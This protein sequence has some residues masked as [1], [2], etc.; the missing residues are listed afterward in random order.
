M[1]CLM[2]ELKKESFPWNPIEWTFSL[3]FLGQI[4]LVSIAYTAIQFYYVFNP[5]SPSIVQK[6]FAAP[7]SAEEEQQ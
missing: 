1:I 6:G 5:L 3:I 4:F 2:Q 7:P